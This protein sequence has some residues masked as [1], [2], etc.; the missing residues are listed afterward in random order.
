MTESPLVSVVIPAYN[1]ART[2]DA[3]LLS[4]C[5]QEYRALEIIVV[6][7]GS[8]DATRAIAEDHAARDPRVRVLNQANAGL[9]AARNAGWRN[10]R[11]DLI[12]FLDADDVWV[13]TK[14]ERQ[15]RVFMHGTDRLG[16]VYCGSVRINVDGRVTNRYPIP[17]V[18]GDVLAPLFG[19]NFVGNGSAAMISRAALIH[20]DG[21][22][23]ALRGADAEGCEDYLLQC[24]IAEKFHF[25]VVPDLLVGYRD[26]PGSMSSNRP[27]MLRSWLL[28]AE[29]MR[30]RH[31][32]RTMAINFGVRSYATWLV[33]D[34]LSNRDVRQFADLARLI[35]RL[36]GAI[37]FPIPLRDVPAEGLRRLRSRVRSWFQEQS[38][39]QPAAGDARFT[40][41][42]EDGG[43][44]AS[45][46]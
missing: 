10:A 7:D 31:P 43:D 41:W 29:E 11:S 46:V 45:T 39:R 4:A 2:L 37:A 36:P 5:A 38:R 33:L 30:D 22:D 19:G 18:D 23:A 3:T 17:Q 34:A 6:N 9:A 26:A 8:T 24:R 14:I 42:S 15:V 44:D 13:R 27:R 40:L 35:M 21:F 32:H 12:A 25:G 20:A 16:L 1:A 28:V